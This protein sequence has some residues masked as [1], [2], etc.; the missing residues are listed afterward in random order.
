MS[1]NPYAAPRTPSAELDPPPQ[2]SGEEW[3][4]KYRQFAFVVVLAIAFTEGFLV[5]V[6][7]PARVLVALG[8]ASAITLWCGLDARVH[9]KLMLRSY[10]WTLMFTWPVG[11]GVYLVWTRGAKGLVTYVLLGLACVA[12]AGAGAT[13]ASFVISP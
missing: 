4:R 11:V 12:A 9:G 13:V 10:A 6:N 2:S 3:V 1:Q 8:L 7:T 5:D